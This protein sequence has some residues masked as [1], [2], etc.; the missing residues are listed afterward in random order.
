MDESNRPSWNLFVY[1]IS[2]PQTV[3]DILC[4]S[5]TTI[6]SQSVTRSFPFISSLRESLS[7]R[8]MQRFTSVKTL[9]ETADSIRSLVRI[10]KRKLN[11]RY[12]SSCHCSTR[13]PG[14]TIIQRFKSPR[15]SNSLRNSPVI[16]VLPAP[17]SSAKI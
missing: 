9:P 5:S 15:T 3:A 6:K 11:F 10:S 7:K 13:L 1:L 4:A 14:V 16:I 8:T 2:P 17:G 12:N